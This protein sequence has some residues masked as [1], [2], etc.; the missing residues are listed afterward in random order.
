M[1]RNIIFA[2]NHDW[3]Q[4][5]DEIEWNIFNNN[6]STNSLIL[7]PNVYGTVR[8]DILAKYRYIQMNLEII[9]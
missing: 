7:S 2:R 3:F 9:N 8:G 5:G 1:G 6:G 4:D